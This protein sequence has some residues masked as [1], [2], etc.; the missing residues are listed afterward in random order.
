MSE[1]TLKQGDCYELIKQL[2]DNSIDLIVT[3]PPYLFQRGGVSHTEFGE[4]AGNRREQIRPISDGFDFSILEEYKR[5]LKNMNMY[6]WCSEMQ[7]G[8]LL[9][10]L[11]DYNTDIIVW[12]KS[13]PMP[14]C[15][16]AYLPDTE[17]CVFARDK[18]VR[19]YG[20]AET[21]H[22]F[23]QTAINQKDK[24]LYDH[25]TIKPLEIISNLIINSSCEGQTVLD[26]F[27][28]SGTTG[29][30]CKLLN[31]NFI[32]FEIDEKFFDVAKQ[33]IEKTNHFNVKPNLTDNQ[34][35]L[36]DM[37]CNR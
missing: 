17:F 2:P 34:L 8:S 23:Y 25:P 9:N 32:G 21:K 35:N 33:R 6:V 27:M 24:A 10:E 15:N 1:I 19:L 12:G 3:D 37:E 22:K 31:R 13:N 4:R 18:G 14:L 7:L 36:W 26:T 5:V 20:S 29:C 28:G 30:A 16:N 11:K